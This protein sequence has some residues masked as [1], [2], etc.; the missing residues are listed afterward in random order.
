MTATY[1]DLCRR[2]SS[3]LLE[4]NFLFE[5]RALVSQNAIEIAQLHAK[6]IDGH[7]RMRVEVDEL[8][9]SFSK[10]SANISLGMERCTFIS[11][12]ICATVSMLA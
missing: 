12:S 3:R 10:M 4:L 7:R 11:S 9:L 8:C 5:Q 2:D 1:L 6:V